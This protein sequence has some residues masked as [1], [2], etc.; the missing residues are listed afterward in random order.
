MMNKRSMALLLAASLAAGA[1]LA[2]TKQVVKIGAI[3]PM[4]GSRVLPRHPRRAGTEDEGSTRSTRPAE[5]TA[6][7]SR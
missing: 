3:Y 2:Q 7:R 6:R 5:S 4:S 1:A